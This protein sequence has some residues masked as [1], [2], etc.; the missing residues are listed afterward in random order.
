MS[1]LTGGANSTLFQDGNVMQVQNALVEEVYTPD[2]RTG[3]VRISYS[4]PG[5]REMI[6]T[7][8]LQLNVN[9]NTILIN[10]YNE[11]IS[12]C[13]ILKGMTINAWF[14]PDFTNSTPPQTNAYRIVAFLPAPN[15]RVLVDR[16]ASID[17][18]NGFLYVG[19]PNN[20]ADQIRFT[21]SN[22]TQ[23]LDQ[24]N[25]PIPLNILQPG[26]MIRVEYGD[27]ETASIPPQTPAFS[28]KMITY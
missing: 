10:Q 20:M 28:I 23:I 15:V 6:F 12:L 24:N 22:L 11:S 5:E 13:R 25:N 21:I 26:Q 27:F 1:D 7:N 16:I 4:F 14:S 8:L 19:N 2:S 18:Q 17:D 9:W 3:Y